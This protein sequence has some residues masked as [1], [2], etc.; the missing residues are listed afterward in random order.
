MNRA[1]GAAAPAPII[2]TALFGTQDHARLT[3]QRRAHFPPERN[4]LEAHLTL[5]HHLPPSLAEEVKHRLRVET[6]GLRAPDARI[7]G[8][9]GLGRGVAYRIESPAL[10]EL[11]DRLA[12]VF[13]G[14]LT[15][16]D[17]AP[18]R[19]HIT[20]QNK[21]TPEEARALKVALEADFR[22]QPLNIAGLA[23]WW[24]RG[25]PW[26]MHSRHMYA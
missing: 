2:V 23:S 22:P 17:H 13:A 19:P 8:V 20:V 4:W 21:V 18:W 14:V 24:Y 9:I 6:R 10:A 3:A 11:R 7:T 26:E 25:G 12:H 1:G 15:P 5:F 16:Q